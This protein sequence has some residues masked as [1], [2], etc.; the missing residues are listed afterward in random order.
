MS[1]FDRGLQLYFAILAFITMLTI[2]W[3]LNRLL[4]DQTSAATGWP[5]MI[6]IAVGIV[7]LG[8]GVRQWRAPVDREDTIEQYPW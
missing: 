2:V 1:V 6:A 8:I 4:L 7:L 5:L 3:G